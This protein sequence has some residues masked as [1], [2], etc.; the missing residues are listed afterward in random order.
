M[1]KWLRKYNKIILVVGGS[2]LMVAF[3]LP[4]TLNRIGRE[5]QN[6]TV[7]MIDGRKV[8]AVTLAR[9]G[10]EMNIVEESLLGLSMR[11][12]F[13]IDNAAHWEML[14]REAEAGGFAGGTG[15]GEIIAADVAPAIA[16][17]R[18]RSLPRDQQSPELF[19]QVR[20]GALEA[21]RTRMASVAQKVGPAA[22]DR[23]F[24]R[25]AGIMLMRGA[26]DRAVRVSEPEALIL[27]H[28]LLDRAEVDAAVIHASDLAEAVQPP[29]E[30]ALKAHFESY[31]AV[32]PGT[33]EPG[34][35]Y[36]LPA[37]VRLEW[38][39]IDRTSL[40]RLLN[41]DPIE[42]NKRWKGA[43]DK[44]PGEF[45]AEKEKI[46]NELRAEQIIQ[47]IREADQ[48][49]RA[50]IAQEQKRLP[51]DGRWKRVPE[52]WR[53][54]AR[55]L[56][57][58]AFA[59]K[60]KLAARGVEYTP[61]VSTQ[62]EFL[63]A[64]TLRSVPGVGE[65]LLPIGARKVPLHEMFPEV[66]E[67]GGKEARGPQVGVLVGPAIDLSGNYH[68]F[69][70]LAARPEGPPASL[71]EVRDQVTRHVRELLAYEQVAAR[72]SEL[73]E[74]AK[75]SGLLAVTMDYPIATPTP[76]F[77]S[78]KRAFLQPVALDTPALRDAV[79]ALAAKLD[80]TKPVADAPPEARFAVVPVRGALSVAAI[81]IK[82]INVLTKDEFDTSAL[83]IAN[84][85]AQQDDR[86]AVDDP[87]TW[88]RMKAR[89]SFVEVGRKDSDEAADE[90]PA[91]APKNAPAP[92]RPIP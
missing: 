80:P 17:N 29:T 30:E 54:S 88:E 27:G 37:A 19:E 56:D 40:S 68:Y 9:A 43:R 39:T 24:S 70:L 52:D 18:L 15:Q 51:E 55:S 82:G 36:L 44:Y 84:F 4:S 25:F 26:Y 11:E 87:F 50:E 3:L 22:A 59:V 42:V 7:A 89:R 32:A 38:L 60:D 47:T 62:P 5:Q 53:T 75:T 71:D 58:I 73:L 14:A 85:A 65:A 12:A 74:K 33:G 77:V 67:I 69:R 41:P 28:D 78:R 90:P 57:A 76:G 49:V 2:L 83:A 1:L 23:A 13:R 45:A 8:S 61:R 81:E 66:K 92:T 16:Q 21:I 86:G 35:G 79:M 63:S 72:A 6:R 34:F 20:A 10:Q 91:D 48:I 64:P 31:K 46:E